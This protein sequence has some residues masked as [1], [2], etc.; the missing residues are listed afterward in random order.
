MANEPK[1]PFEGW[2]NM[3]WTKDL[4]S[5][6]SQAPKGVPGGNTEMIERI[7]KLSR[8]TMGFVEERMRKDMETVRALTEAKTPMDVGRIQMEFFQ[9]LVTDYN[10]QAMKMAEEAGKN[11]TA[12]FGKWPG[13]PGK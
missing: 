1:N 7:Q 13:M 6:W 10:R 2:P 11:L 5:F 12:A 9:G 4:A 8:E 3:D